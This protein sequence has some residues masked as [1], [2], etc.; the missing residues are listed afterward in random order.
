MRQKPS[1]KLE[2]FTF[3]HIHKIIRTTESMDEASAKLNV[4]SS[5]LGKFLSSTIPDGEKN[6]KISYRIIKKMSAEEVI[7][8]YGEDAYNKPLKHFLILPQEYPLS[9]IHQAIR[10][11]IFIGAV[12]N[13]LKVNRTDLAR[14]LKNI[15]KIDSYLSYKNLIILS[16]Q[17]LEN[18]LGPKYKQPWLTAKNTLT[19]FKNGGLQA[20][21]PSSLTI[22]YNY[23]DVDGTLEQLMNEYASTQLTPNNEVDGENYKDTVLQML[24][25]IEGGV[26]VSKSPP[27]IT[28]YAKPDG[29]QDPSFTHEPV[30]SQ[31]LKSPFMSDSPYMYVY[32]PFSYEGYSLLN[33]NPITPPF[34]FLSQVYSAT[35][36]NEAALV[37]IF[38][39]ET[40]QPQLPAT[41]SIVSKQFMPERANQC[42]R[43]MYQ[44]SP[45]SNHSIFT[46]Q[47]AEQQEENVYQAK[48][49][50]LISHNC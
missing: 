41:F 3:G 50:N 5:T 18:R 27:A 39:T 25:S 30:V 22:A 9:M 33:K 36:A 11:N 1:F 44:S 16:E 43:K 31:Q 12:A 35:V 6:F 29:R 46:N 38:E 47:Q 24:P 28:T 45:L 23:T 20:S 21:T 7:K 37:A 34:D 42:P 17:E 19:F 32:S 40:Y 13:K 14:Y 4:A 48:V 26:A 49:C 10:E 15:A 2:K 8:K